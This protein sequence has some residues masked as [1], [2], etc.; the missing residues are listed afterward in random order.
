MP[1]PSTGALH[2]PHHT[3]ARLTEEAC[4]LGPANKTDQLTLTSVLFILLQHLSM[5]Q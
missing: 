4:I 2:T 1:A 3:A 5:F